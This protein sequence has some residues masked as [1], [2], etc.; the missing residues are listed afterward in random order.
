MTCVKEDLSAEECDKSEILV[1]KLVQQES[2]ITGDVPDCD[3]VD[4]Q[5]L[6]R[7]VLHRQKLLGDLRRGSATEYLGQLKWWSKRSKKTQVKTG[8]SPYG[9]GSISET[10]TTVVSIRVCK[11]TP[12][13]WITVA[14]R[15][16]SRN[17]KR[18]QRD[19]SECAEA[20]VPKAEYP[21]RK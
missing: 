21:N 10:Y 13:R 19:E 18:V 1:L 16:P 17:Q 7:K 14:V 4:Q 11:Q 20:G 15:T 6:S 5:S 9:K 12:L 2:Q 3:A 8:Q